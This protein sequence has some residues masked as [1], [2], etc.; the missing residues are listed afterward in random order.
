MP[1][2]ATFRRQ[3]LPPVP[4]MDAPADLDRR[5]HFRKKQR[6]A[7]ADEPNEFCGAAQL[8]SPQTEPARTP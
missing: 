4:R 6:H 5:Q 2:T 7:E 1:H 8:G 3:A